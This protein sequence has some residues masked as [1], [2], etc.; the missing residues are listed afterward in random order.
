[1]Q[2]IILAEFIVN[3]LFLPNHWY[4][5]FLSQQGMIFMMDLA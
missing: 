1:M 2:D 3:D 4:I 5:Y